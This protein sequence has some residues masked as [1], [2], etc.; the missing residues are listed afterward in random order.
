MRMHAQ[1]VRRH[2][3]ACKCMWRL[4]VDVQYPPQSRLHISDTVNWKRGHLLERVDQLAGI[5]L[6]LDTVVLSFDTQALGIQTQ[7]L[8]LLRKHL[9]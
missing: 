8:V 1:A 6:P 7:V 3:H 4:E 9:T 2:T 5:E